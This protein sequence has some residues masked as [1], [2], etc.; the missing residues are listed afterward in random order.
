MATLMQASHQWATRPADQRFDSIPSML[1]YLDFL[2]SNSKRLAMPNRALTVRPLDSDHHWEVEVCYGKEQYPA[3]FT[4]WAFGQVCS[5]AGVPASYMRSGMPAAL[6]SANLDWALKHARGVDDLS[7]L[8]R[9]YP[10]GCDFHAPGRVLAAAN[11]PRF[12]HLDCSDI[13]HDVHDLYGDGITG[14][15]TIPGEFGQQ[16]AITKA[17]TTLYAS[18]RDSWGFLADEKRRLT[19]PNRRNGEAGSLARGFYI[20]NSSVGASRFVL[21]MFLFDY[22]CC[23]RI[24]WGAEGHR[25][26]AFKHTSGAP[27]RFLEEVK[28]I[29][30]EFAE[31]SPKGIEETIAAAQARKVSDD[32][33]TFLSKHFGSDNMAAKIK[34]AY[35]ADEGLDKPMQ[36]LWDVVTGATAYARTLEYADARVGIERQA[37]KLL[38][39]AA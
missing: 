14:D 3:E 9:R 6:V 7:V 2:K 16:V 13:W 23:N 37:G 20:T 24:I 21:G 29:L 39:M 34:L 5:L 10:H 31:S 30:K 4:H 12:G 25:E 28:P 19:V 33:D 11:G 18:D 35:A 38:A 22:V 27:S 17:N 36:T 32:L 1:C 15:W 26:I 8:V